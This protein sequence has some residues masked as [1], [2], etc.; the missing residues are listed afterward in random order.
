[1]LTQILPVY[2]IKTMH[3]T[4]ERGVSYPHGVY[5]CGI[6]V[7]DGSRIGIVRSCTVNARH[8]LGW[9]PM[10]SHRYGNDLYRVN[11]NDKWDV[12][13][14]SKLGTQDKII[15]DVRIDVVDGSTIHGT[16]CMKI[17][18]HYWPVAVRVYGQRLVAE[19]IPVPVSSMRNA[20]Q[21]NW[22]MLKSEGGDKVYDLGYVDQLEGRVVMRL[23]NNNQTSFH[24]TATKSVIRGGTN[25]VKTPDGLLSCGHQVE[26]YGDGVRDYR[27]VFVLV[28]DEYPYDVI[29]HTRPLKLSK[30][31]VS[32]GIQFPIGLAWDGDRLMVSYGVADADNVI[33]EVKLNDVMNMML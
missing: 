23:A 26:N 24:R 32:Q 29:S 10:R 9:K 27:S 2:E 20:S 13:A 8:R 22:V 7:K 21:K 17:N 12:S 5:N 31:D 11:F 30:S 19:R 6:H 28:K 25:Y 14:F 4:M 3:S 16:G 33:G 1:M 18:E 15:H